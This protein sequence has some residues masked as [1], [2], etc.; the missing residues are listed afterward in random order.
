MYMKLV[1]FLKRT[2][3]SVNLFYK[4]EYSQSMIDDVY[5]NWY[6]YRSFAYSYFF[7]QLFVC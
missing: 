3:Y 6:K 1:H 4:V 5:D 2:F 7:S